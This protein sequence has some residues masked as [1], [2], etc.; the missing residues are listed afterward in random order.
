M[1]VNT[2]IAAVLAL[3]TFGVTAPASAQQAS[4]D[5]V[6]GLVKSVMDATYGQNY[7]AK[8]ACWAF[9]WKN[10]QGESADYCM[11]PG[12][13]QIIEGPRGKTLYLNTFSA[14]DIRGDARY[15]YSQVQPGLMGAFKIKVGGKQGWIYEANDSGTDYGSAGDCGCTRARLIKLSNSGDYGWLFTSGGTW[16]GVTVADYSI[17]AAIKGRIT[18][19][20]KIPQ[21]TEKA[22]GVKY[23]ISVKEDPAA[24]GFFPLHVVKTAADGKTE[25]FDVAFDTTKSIY[26]LPPGR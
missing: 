5:D 15:G 20:S 14:T 11:R 22:Q 2:M 13:P 6:A 7:D 18:D 23:D 16:Q 24:Q 17:V 12:T 19:I 8:N 1:N 3:G 9:T 21:V 10:D 25:A 4:N 26:A